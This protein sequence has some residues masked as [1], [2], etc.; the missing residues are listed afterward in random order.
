MPSHLVGTRVENWKSTAA[1][2]DI[3]CSTLSSATERTAPRPLNN[4]ASHCFNSILTEEST[5]P[6]TQIALWS[7][8]RVDPNIAPVE[9][10]AQDLDEDRLQAGILKVEVI[11]ALPKSGHLWPPRSCRDDVNV[12]AAYA[13]LGIKGRR[14]SRDSDET[15]YSQARA[16]RSIPSSKSKTGHPRF[17]IQLLRLAAVSPAIVWTASLGS[18][19]FNSSR[20]MSLPTWTTARPLD[21]TYAALYGDLPT[22]SIFP[23]YFSEFQF[24][25]LEANKASQ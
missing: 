13:Q 17:Y 8:R 24:T 16:S 21:A 1:A 4:S 22:H 12:Y 3:T 19:G 15:S 10:V 7:Y 2:V 20:W 6:G 14:R 11:M 5:S 9:Q 23:T 25:F 18:F